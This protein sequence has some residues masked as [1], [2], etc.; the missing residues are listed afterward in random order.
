MEMM[1]N[2]LLMELKFLKKSNPE[3]CNEVTKLFAKVTTFKRELTDDEARAFLEYIQ[4]RE[5]GEKHPVI[6]F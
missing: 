1:N 3:L 2:L 5:E 4:K 6:C